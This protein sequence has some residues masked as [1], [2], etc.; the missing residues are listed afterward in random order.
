MKVAD[1]Q[2]TSRISKHISLNLS[3]ENKP[4]LNNSETNLLHSQSIEDF[5]F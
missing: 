2:V 3:D 1:S 5:N 4:S